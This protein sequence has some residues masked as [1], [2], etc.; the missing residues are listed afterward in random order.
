MT[1]ETNNL[2]EKLV[3]VLSEQVELQQKLIA[4]QAEVISL[5]AKIIE[6]SPKRVDEDVHW[7]KIY[8]GLSA[9][10]A[11]N[12]DD[13]VIVKAL[14]DWMFTFGEKYLKPYVNHQA[15]A[16]AMA[17]MMRGIAQKLSELEIDQNTNKTVVRKTLDFDKIRKQK[18]EVTTSNKPKQKPLLDD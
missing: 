2:E 10:D 11:L 17:H 14:R 5:Q 3:T 18:S 9:E 6:L 8:G 16:E 13:L 1:K 4:S 12:S 15:Y 7:N